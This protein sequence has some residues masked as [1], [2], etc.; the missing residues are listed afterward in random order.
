MNAAPASPTREYIYSGSLLAKLEGANT[1]YYYPDQ[2][3]TRMTKTGGT[4]V[5]QGNFPFGENWYGSTDKWKFTTYERDTESGNDYAMMRSYVNRY[6]RFLTPDPAGAAAVDPTNPQTWNRYGYVGNDPVNFI[7]PLG[8]CPAPGVYS[9]SKTCVYVQ[10]IGDHLDCSVNGAPM[11][12]GYA[13]H[14]W[15]VE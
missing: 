11:D 8:L 10:R 15:N 13:F 7:D 6:G 12:C 3:S 9:K 2:L 1:T 14:R 4:T 5:E